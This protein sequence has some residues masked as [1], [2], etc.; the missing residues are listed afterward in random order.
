MK[1]A[2]IGSGSWGTAL[3]NVLAVNNHDVLIWGKNVDEVVDIEKYHQNEAYFPDVT[4]NKNLHASPNFDDIIDY[5]IFLLAVPSIAIEEV[6]KKLSAS[7]VKP[8][9]I[10]N[11]A[12]GF[13][14]ISHDYL[15][16]VIRD[17]FDPKLLKGVISL[18]GP[19]HAEEV[20]IGQLTAVNAV[21]SDLSA[22]NLVQSLFSNDTFRVYVNDDEVGAQI[23]VAVKNV[24]ALASGIAA[25]LGY[26]DNTRAALITR[27][28]AEMTRYGVHFGGRIETFL[29]LCGVGDLIVT[30]TSHH[31]RNFQAGYAV[32]Q[33]H[34]AV[35]FNKTNTKTVEGVVAAKIVYDEAIKNNIEMPI[36][37]EVYKVFYEN[38][39]PNEAILDLMRRDLKHESK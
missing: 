33:A 39:D 13:H 17:S 7:V 20:V 4:L 31:S 1:I 16:N 23:G 18:I 38:K 12:K 14:P 37:T 11:V 27:G 8:V 29:G 9:Y 30:A 35:E 28:L 21:S 5:D 19:S 3:G 24:L 22:A 26:G 32:G 10:I 15:M 2:I 36:T 34:S 25:G 6:C